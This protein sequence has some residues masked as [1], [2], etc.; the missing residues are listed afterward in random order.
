MELMSSPPSSSPR[1]TIVDIIDD[2]PESSNQGARIAKDTYHRLREAIVSGRFQPNERLVEASVAKVIGAG[3]SAVRA[4]LVRLDQEGLV[5]LEPNRGARVRLID[6]CEAL[7]IEE[8][9][10]ALE[11]FLARRAAARVKPEDLHRLDAAIVGMRARVREGDSAGY[12]ELNP[13]FHQLI[14]AAADHRTAAR[15]LAGLKSQSIR[16]QYQTA[17][18]PGRAERSLREHEAIVEALRRGDSEAAEAA[19]KAHLAEVVDT[20][21]WVIQMQR[22]TTRWQPPDDLS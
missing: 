22:G 6:E 5:V 21:E 17:L 1:A 19:M 3:R 9:R 15:V 11:G 12:S 2:D 13:G 8:V 20:L 16:F 7:E 4:A 14:W 18:R 10:V